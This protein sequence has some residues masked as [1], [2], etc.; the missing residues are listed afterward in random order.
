[1]ASKDAQDAAGSAAE[2]RCFQ[3]QRSTQPACF[4]CGRPHALRAV[5]CC[6]CRAMKLPVI[7]A[8]SP[9]RK[10]L[11]KQQ[12]EMDPMVRGGWCGWVVMMVVV[13]RVCGGDVCACMCCDGSE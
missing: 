7:G 6:A 8:I 2:R 13:G 12:S 1:M 9:E 11:L 4:D 3:S 10:L 5:L